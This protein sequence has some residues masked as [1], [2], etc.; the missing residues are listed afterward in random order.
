MNAILTTSRYEFENL[1][2]KRSVWVISAAYL[3]LN[4]VICLS[5]ELR[6]SYF[7]TIE[8]VPVMLNNFVLPIVLVGILITTLSSVF[9]GDKEQGIGQIPAA[10]L[11]GRKG[12]SVAK[13]IGAI[14]FSTIAIL[15]LEAI[16]LGVSLCFSLVNGNTE[17]RY[18]GTEVELNPI[19]TAWQHVGFSVVTLIFGC[20]MLTVLILFI[21]CCT[22][23]TLSAVSL[24]GIIVLIEFI[25]NKFSFP[26]FLQEFNI[27]V[28]FRPYYLFI[29]EIFN[30]SPII[31]LLFLLLS[32]LPLLLFAVRQ[33]IK[34]GI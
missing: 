3:A 8:N 21:S 28:F 26:T 1:I 14:S 19:W 7:S 11:I 20:I 5:K 25:I 23:N 12:R 27:W 22:Q 31:N 13:L 15:I 18:V 10:C 16:T 29:T 34:N 24:S 17:I 30:V 33:I 32:F 4:I 2:C 6:E 9:A